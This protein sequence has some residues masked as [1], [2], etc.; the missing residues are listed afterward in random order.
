MA[1]EVV[2]LGSALE[3]HLIF[4][5]GS[6]ITTSTSG[7]QECSIKALCPDAAHVFDFVPKAGDTYNTVFGNSYLPDDFKVDYTGGGAQLDYLKGNAAQITLTFKRPD[8]TTAGENA[9]A[10]ATVAVDSV[11]NYK[12]LL[13]GI[14]P[15]PLRDVSGEAVTALGF[16]EPVVTVKYNAGT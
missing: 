12:S 2:R 15:V 16:P 4:Q 5:D 7:I 10:N 14:A 11:I 3:P 9:R 8:P 13:G 6:T 1:G